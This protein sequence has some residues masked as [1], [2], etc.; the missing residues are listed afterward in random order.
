MYGDLIQGAS[1]PIEEL[2]TLYLSKGFLYTSRD[3]KL[4]TRFVD[5]HQIY[6]LENS[7]YHT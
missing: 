2:P 1:L 6:L 5:N 7:V 4:I 3:L